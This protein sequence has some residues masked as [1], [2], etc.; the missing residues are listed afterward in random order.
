[1][2]NGMSDTLPEVSIEPAG[3]S[4]WQRASYVWL[5]PIT[6]LLIAL[7]VAWQAYTNRGPLV[8]IT[9]N[10]ASGVSV[11]DTELRYRDIAVGVVEDLKFSPNLDAV[12]ASVRLSKDIAPFVDEDAAFWI[13]RPELTP[14]GVSGLDTVL[15][16]V[17][18][19]G[20]WDHEVGA[21]RASFAGL[22]EPPLFHAERSGLRLVL[23]TLAGGS[24]T[25]NSPIT[26]RG[27]EVGQVGRAKISLDGT[28]ATADAIIYA[29]HARL[30]SPNTRFWDT[31][32]FTF[33]VGPS[34]AEIDFSSLAT[35]V[36]GGIT[37]DTF[38][39]GGGVVPDG[40]VFDLYAEQS[41]ARDSLFRAQEV[42]TL[43]LRLVFSENIAGLAV[44]APVELG[45]LRIGSV[46]SISGI[47]DEETFGDNRVRLNVLIEIQP[48]RLGLQDDVSPAAALAFFQTR[49]DEGLRARLATS[50]L[51]STG[52]KVELVDD[53][54]AP[55]AQLT[56]FGARVPILPTTDSEISDVAATVEG[57]MTRF[58]DLP[59]ED[60]LNSAID[61]LQSADALVSDPDLR[62][63][64]ADARALLG[65]I[66]AITASEG[67][68]RVP[69]ALQEVLAQ[70]DTL[71][72]DIE[73]AQ[74]ANRLA[75]AAD[76][77]T[78]AA[79]N[80]SASLQDVPTLVAQI[81]A[82][83]RNAADLP[84]EDLTAEI[85][86]LTRAANAILQ[87][88]SAQ[89]LPETLT[90]VLIRFETLLAELDTAQTVTRLTG[91]LDAAAEAASK[92]TVSIDGVPALIAELNS[93]ASTAADLPLADLVSQVTDLARAAEVILGD[94]A[95]RRLPAD[96]GAALS[97]INAT[98]AALRA[99]G[100]VEN[101]NETLASARRA[102][103]SVANSVDALPDLVS[104]TQA[105][106][107]QA[108]ATI[109]GY[110]RGDV[111]S[112]D[113]QTALRDIS[114][115]ADALASL[116][117]MLERNPSSL[118]RGR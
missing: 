34:G 16:G 117:R 109:A 1:M 54:A 32:G 65:D 51:L 72:S 28:F 42:D 104:R 2:G 92:V 20:S 86:E 91:A 43:Q 25:D 3:R 95:T 27:I 52:L 115:A 9:F 4:F 11:R 6:A 24:L 105:L 7:S 74:L 84:L 44:E 88:D 110:D 50:G 96:L 66:R 10:D 112:R 79:N 118:L 111:I 107:T 93:L 73:V 94:D 76:A 31:S 46:Q 116:A 98:L 48:A 19:A 58:N 103:A 77:A 102:A 37:F 57:A 21:A 67:L 69:Q 100:T 26:F 30:I 14:Q 8:E 13:V 45:G 63:T 81:N 70:L 87:S 47:V 33:S 18:I 68:Q 97:E 89:T 38:V 59:I 64:P 41:T 56:T 99:G 39:S 62:E 78:G 85:T 12:I 75:T 15:T 23:R 5:I 55:P 36:S 60:L 114:R 106:L 101:V 40:T 82:V 17:Y 29:Q 35:L 22:D 90:A 113:A 80:V 53:P 61:F 49:V 108:S 83:A 71:L